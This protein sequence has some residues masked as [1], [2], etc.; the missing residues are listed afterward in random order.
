MHKDPHTNGWVVHE[1]VCCGNRDYVELLPTS[2]YQF[3]VHGKQYTGGR[4]D[5][6]SVRGLTWR[7]LWIPVFGFVP[8][9]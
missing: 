3:S 5:E 8:F 4:S 9:R 6:G 7:I 2:P 1:M